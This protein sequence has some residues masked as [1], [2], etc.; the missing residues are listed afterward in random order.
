[1]IYSEI[2]ISASTGTVDQT[3]PVFAD[4][5]KPKKF[6]QIAPEKNDLSKSGQQPLLT[7]LKFE[8]AANLR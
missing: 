1:V 7:I 3:P 4:H 8:S 6:D 5:R 2:V